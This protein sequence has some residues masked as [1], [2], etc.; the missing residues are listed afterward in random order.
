MKSI[1]QI[2]TDAQINV[3]GID[4]SNNG[5]A[6]P[7]INADGSVIVG[8]YRNDDHEIRPY[9]FV[10][11]DV[12]GTV[13]PGIT[14]PE[15][16]ARSMTANAAPTQQ[17]Q[18]ALAQHSGQTLAVARNALNMYLSPSFSSYAA[19]PHNISPASGNGYMP[20][21]NRAVYV[22]GSFGVGGMNDYSNHNTVGSTGMLF[23]LTPEIAFGVGVLRGYNREETYL[24]GNSRTHTT[25]LSM[26]GA[27]EPDHSGVRLYG[28]ATAAMLDVKNDRRFLNGNTVQSARG[29]TDGMGYG[30]AMRAGYVLD[31]KASTQVMPYVEADVSRTNMDGYTEQGGVFAGEVGKVKSDYVASRLG[32]EISHPV[33][34]NTTMRGRAA[35]GHRYSDGGSVVSTV[36]GFSQGQAVESGNRNWVEVGM[37]VNHRVT[38][39]MSL[40]GDLSGRIGR[41][42]E[43]AVSA[44][45][46]IVWNF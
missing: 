17:A 35:W 30:L 9:I 40:T 20:P 13:Q 18:S 14:T 2:L 42:S 26:M 8:H 7:T 32:A 29:E 11:K 27:Y 6:S 16:L 4:F 24:K 25:G 45:A 10:M 28:I 46:G 41:T 34:D 5:D 33:T 43:P 1:R 31:R 22:T 37:N 12:G 21:L 19:A 39:K 38:E 23:K 44:I 15:E 3:S 36:A